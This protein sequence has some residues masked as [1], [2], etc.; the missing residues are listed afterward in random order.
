[1]NRGLKALAAL[2]ALVSSIGALGA[3]DA[4]AAQFHIE[5]HETV[6]TGT[7]TATHTLEFTGS[8]AKLKCGK[9]SFGSATETTT[10]STMALVE[11]SY[12]ECTLGGVPAGVN[13]NGCKYLFTT[14]KAPA[15]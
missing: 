3:V 1:M 8:G 5:A 14:N 12:A 11:A 7:A 13:M 9:A 2:V 15:E 6:V 10:A 4:A